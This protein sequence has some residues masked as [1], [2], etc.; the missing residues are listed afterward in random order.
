MNDS[1]LYFPQTYTLIS[2]RLGGKVLSD[3]HFIVSPDEWEQIK[4][5]VD[6]FYKLHS[7]EEIEAHNRAY[8]QKEVFSL[9]KHQIKFHIPSHLTSL[10]KF[11]RT[12]GWLY[13]LTAEGRQGIKIGETSKNLRQRTKANAK[14]IQSPVTIIDA[15]QSSHHKRLEKQLHEIFKSKHI[16]G[17]WFDLTDKDVKDIPVIAYHLNIQM[18]VTA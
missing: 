17:D 14:E 9:P 5:E 2:G 13:W 12:R 11:T 3:K 6:A 7:A 16:R 8:D 15:F 18:E 4:Q 1:G 10:P